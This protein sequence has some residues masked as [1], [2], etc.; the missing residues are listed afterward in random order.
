MG[1]QA[2]IYRDVAKEL[3]EAI[4]AKWAD[5]DRGQ[6]SRPAQDYPMPLPAVL[7]GVSDVQ[8]RTA[9]GCQVGEAVVEIAV[10]ADCGSDTHAGGEGETEA[11]RLLEMQDKVYR[12]LDGKS[13]AS[14][15]SMVRESTS[16]PEWRGKMV[17]MRSGWR[18]SVQERRPMSEIPVEIEIEISRG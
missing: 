4:G 15:V 10:V 7:I 13:G 9:T 14:Y 1:Y 11:L 12:A 17:V 5:L 8:W 3:R 2:D 6:L 18:C 16:K